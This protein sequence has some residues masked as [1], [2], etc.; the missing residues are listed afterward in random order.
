MITCIVID[1]DKTIAS[2]FSEILEYMGFNVL[3]EGYNG[4]DAVTL[5]KEHHPDLVFTDIMMPITDG[6]YAIE[7]IKELEPNAKFVVVTADSTLETKEKLEK[8]AIA[9]IIYKPF[10]QN[11]I[12]KVLEKEYK[13]NAQGI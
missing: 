8:L 3:A 2:L 9:A 4:S 10:N 12:K 6:F 1:D 5:Y 7:K 11:E 13:I